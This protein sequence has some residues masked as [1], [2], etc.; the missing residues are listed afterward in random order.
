MMRVPAEQERF[1]AGLDHQHRLHGEEIVI[2]HIT[3]KV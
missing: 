1:D 3:F 2:T